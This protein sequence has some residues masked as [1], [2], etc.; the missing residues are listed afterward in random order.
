MSRRP[1]DDSWF[2]VVARLRPLLASESA[3]PNPLEPVPAGTAVVEG[4]PQVLGERFDV[5][6]IG[7][8]ASQED[9]FA[10]PGLSRIVDRTLRGLPSAVLAV[11]ASSA[12]K[13]HTLFRIGSGWPHS[14]VNEA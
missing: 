4:K 6:A 14:V 7:P 1:P 5:G 2:N 8:R 12:G 10:H 13:T 11:G 9:V 3:N